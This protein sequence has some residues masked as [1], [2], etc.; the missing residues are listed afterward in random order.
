MTDSDMLLRIQELL[1]RE[2]ASDGVEW[3]SDTLE[4]IADLLN[5]NGYRIRDIED[6]DR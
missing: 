5:S 6:R 2:I 3:S 4:L 1:A